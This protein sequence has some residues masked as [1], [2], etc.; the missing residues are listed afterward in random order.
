MYSYEDRSLVAVRN[1]GRAADPAGE[2]ARRNRVNK[3]DQPVVLVTVA[4]Q[5]ALPSEVGWS[6]PWSCC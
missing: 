5:T 2:V 1:D 3:W 4:R 6:M